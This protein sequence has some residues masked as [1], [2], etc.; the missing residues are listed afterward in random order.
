MSPTRRLIIEKR[1]IFRQSR[2][3]PLSLTPVL[4]V[5]GFL[6]IV[7]AFAMIAP[8]AIGLI[9]VDHNWVPFAVSAGLT[10]FCGIALVITC[11]QRDLSLS[12]R[13]T[14]MLTT[15]GWLAIAFFGSLP[16]HFDVFELSVTDAFFEAM[17]GLTTTGSTVIVGLDD[18]PLD[19]LLWRS[20]LQWLGGIGIIGMA[21]V[22]LPFLRV[23]GMQLFQ[24]ERSDEVDKVFPRMTE[25]AV[26]ICLIYVAL[27]VA[28][29]VTLI[30][31]GMSAFDSV[32][33]AM[34]TV[35]TGGFST[36]DR[37]IGGFNLDFEWPLTLFMIA[38]SLPFLRYVSVVRGDWRAVWHDSQIRRFLLFLLLCWVMLAAWM[39]MFEDA[40]FVGAFREASFNV[41]S[42]VSTT[43]FVS[44][45]Y[46]LWGSFA[47]TLFL[48]LTFV[49]GCTGS[50]SGGIKIFRF[51]I[52]G[53]AFRGQM[54]RL[55]SPN[56]AIA[57]KYHHGPV[58][59]G[60][61]VSVMGLLFLF[62]SMWLLVSLVLAA[63][64]LDVLT[65]TSGAATALANVGPGLGP[66]IGP[67]GNFATLP[68]VAKWV[69]AFAMLLGRLEF[70]A[71]LVLL[72][73]GFWRR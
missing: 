48:M 33:H 45:D 41:T 56:R 24:A 1:G 69:L 16:F 17:S 11:W 62:L 44:A 27:T 2:R 55:L 4:F 67:S 64:G 50:T 23:G 49:G 65:A 31:C 25:L 15:F 72:T 20:L 53:L 40:S 22:I 9:N 10:G 54:A 30:I 71:I 29:V 59:A 42:V 34:A 60:L 47:V 51:E 5:I 3:N 70:F 19:L 18:A 14:F 63:L 52:L 73:P 6:L 13:Q 32:N 28:C 21:I 46:Q 58:E 7:E 26:S 61:L 57:L 12:I 8:L 36:S 68:D 43:G 66:I 35:S 37:S 39:Y 38:G